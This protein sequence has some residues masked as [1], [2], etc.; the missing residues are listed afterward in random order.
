MSFTYHVKQGDTGDNIAKKF[1]ITFPSLEKS[2]LNAKWND[3]QINSTLQIPGHTYKVVSGDT[4]D[5]LAKKFGVP[6]S[7]LQAA[8][9]TANWNDLQI[10]E[11]LNV[12]GSPHH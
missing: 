1:D 2:N 9:P 5:A 11:V 6:F 4:G 10:G 8:N 12:A 7:A 3:L